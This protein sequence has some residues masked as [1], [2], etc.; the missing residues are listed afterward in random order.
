MAYDAGR[1]LA[2]SG[3]RKFPSH[4]A[5]LRLPPPP[6]LG[7]DP[8]IAYSSLANDSVE[9]RGSTTKSEWN[10]TT[11]GEVTRSGPGPS[12]LGGGQSR[13]RTSPRVLG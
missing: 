6:V 2:A 9:V 13:S 7:N 8:K 3:P 5:A 11:G 10:C 1:D 12:D 4:V